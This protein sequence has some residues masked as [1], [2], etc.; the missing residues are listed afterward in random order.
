MNA[1]V[2]YS[3]EKVHVLITHIKDYF[4]SQR[5]RN[6]WQ[7]T[8]GREREKMKNKKRKVYISTHIYKPQKYKEHLLRINFTHT[9]T[10][11]VS[12]MCFPLFARALPSQNHILL[13]VTH[14]CVHIVNFF[15]SMSSQRRDRERETDRK[16]MRSLSILSR[17]KC[18]FF[19][20]HFSSLDYF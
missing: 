14:I 9:T 6:F 19:F 5:T 10:L 15:N 8:R 11:S 12:R 3:N 1:K 16:S 17:E 2:I 13:C 18:W 20:L 7:K 4:V